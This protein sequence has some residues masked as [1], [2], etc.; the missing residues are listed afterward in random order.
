MAPV[1]GSPAAAPRLVLASSSAARHR[2][3]TDAGIAHE[4]VV[5]GVDE[6]AVTAD[7]VPELVLELARRKADAVVVTLDDGLVLGCDSLF[8]LDGEA[9][10]KPAGPEEAVVRLRSLRGRDGVLHTGHCLVEVA[11]GRRAEAVASTTVRFGRPTDAEIDAY[12]ATGEPLGVAGGVTLEG[13]SA[14]F[15]D[16]IVGDHS[17]VIGLSLPRLRALLAELGVPVTA[18]WD[19]A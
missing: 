18:L 14:P 9:L 12:V 1:T 13:R 7:D 11:S 17:N 15:I 10:G 6:D 8:E 5:S 19:G 2:L 4:V 16:G 3:L